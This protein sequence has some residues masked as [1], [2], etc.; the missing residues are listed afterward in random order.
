MSPVLASD[1]DRFSQR[2]L[3]I[4]AAGLALCALGWF[5]NPDQFYRAYLVGFLFWNGVALGCL[6]IA[7][8]HQL[9]GGAWGVVIRRILESATRTFPVTA[10][11]FLPLLL[12]IHSLYIWSNPAAVAADTA[13]QHKAAYL[14]VPFFVGRAGLYFAIWLTVA[15]FFN[16]WSLEQDRTGAATWSSKMQRL[17]GP[18]L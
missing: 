6:A 17:A 14:N 18:G 12:G 10:I 4:G 3:L 2:A 11:L 5:L 9:S 13:L 16:K 7:M 1:L 8:L 15:Y